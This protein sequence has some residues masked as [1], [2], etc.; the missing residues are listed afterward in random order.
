[1]IGF[2]LLFLQAKADQ[3][4]G[5]S[6][7]TIVPDDGNVSHADAEMGRDSEELVDELGDEELAKRVR[8]ASEHAAA[9]GEIKVEL[10]GK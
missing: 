2:V 6:Y 3:K 8:E 5:I 10:K 7:V 9:P 1:M 4:R